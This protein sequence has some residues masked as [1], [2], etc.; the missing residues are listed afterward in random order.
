MNSK[1]NQGQ[2]SKSEMTLGRKNYIMIAIGLG[3]IILGMILMA[4]G[5]SDNPEVFNYEMFSWR[6]ITLAPILIVGGFAFEVFAIMKRF[7]E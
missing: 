6:R 2:E 1:K 7:K 3:V 4:G 5:G